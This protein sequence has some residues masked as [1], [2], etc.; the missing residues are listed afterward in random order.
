MV[1]FK[2]GVKDSITIYCSVVIEMV[3]GSGFCMNIKSF[4]CI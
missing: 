3:I 4:Y 1:D 2:D